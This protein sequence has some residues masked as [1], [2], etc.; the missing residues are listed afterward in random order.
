MADNPIDLNKIFNFS[1]TTPLDQVIAKTQQLNSVLDTMLQTAMKSATGMTQSMQQIQKSVESLE[2]EMTQAD[3]TTKKGQETITQGATTTAKAVAQNEEYKKSLAD[4]NETIKTLQGQIDKLSESNKKTGTDTDKQSNSL[5]SL[6]QQLK[7]ATDAY[8]KLGAATDSA[9]KKDAL[10]KVVNLNKAVQDGTK[11]INDAKKA[12]DIANGSYNELAQKVANATK[13]LKAMEGGVGSNSQQFKDLQKQ[14]AE[15][16]EK[17][18]TFDASIG[19][20]QRNVGDYAKATEGLKGQFEGLLGQLGPAGEKIE[21]IGGKA[22]SAGN[23]IKGMATGLGGVVTAAGAFIAASLGNYFTRTAEGAQQLFEVTTKLEYQWIQFKNVL[24]EVGKLIVDDLSGERILGKQ[25]DG[26]KSDFEKNAKE[27]RILQRERIKLTQEESDQELEKNKLVFDSRDKLH[28]SAEERL[29]D[30]KKALVILKELS[31]AATNQAEA[32]AKTKIADIIVKSG[33]PIYP[34]VD[35]NDKNQIA[36]VERRLSI[37]DSKEVSELMIKVNEARNIA[38]AGARRI[39]AQISTLDEEI[40]K[41]EEEL[42]REDLEAIKGYNDAIIKADVN[43]NNELLANIKTSETEKLAALEKNAKDEIKITENARDLALAAA[44]QKAK[45]RIRTKMG[46]AI[47]EAKSPE[48]QQAIIKADEVLAKQLLKI[49]QDFETASG[50]IESDARIKTTAL[51]NEKIKERIDI[52]VKSYSAIKDAEVLAAQQ[53][54]DNNNKVLANLDSTLTSRAQAI[55]DNAHLQ[56]QIAQDVYDKQLALDTAEALNKIATDN[57]VTGHLLEL[58]DKIGKSRQELSNKLNAINQKEVVEAR[59]NIFTTLARDLE[60]FNNLNEESKNKRL[61]EN[62]EEFNSGNIGLIEYQHQR[63]IILKSSADIEAEDKLNNLEKQKKDLLAQGL[64]TE[65][66]RTQIEK[67]Q[68]A[69]RL[70]IADREADLKAQRL[71]QL[72]D[73]ELQLANQT[74]DT[75]TTLLDNE[76][77]AKVQA[78]ESQMSA[79]QENHDKQIILA[80]DNAEIKKQIDLQYAQQQKMIQ[81][82]EAKLKHDQAVIDRDLALAKIIIN[83]AVAITETIAAGGYFAIPLSIIVG[84]LGTLESAKVASTPIPGYATGTEYSK[85]GLA[86]VAEQGP[87]LAI[88]RSGETVLYKEKQIAY[89]NEGTKI[90]NNARTEPILK[91][92]D[93][94]HMDLISHQ[95]VDIGIRDIK[96]GQSLNREVLNELYQIKDATKRNKPTQ[97]NYSKTAGVLWEYKMD[98]SNFVK[99]TKALS[100]GSWSQ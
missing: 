84:A 22:L 96:A 80:G 43:K 62:D 38:F 30:S 88:D 90:L 65:Q 35:I 45:D 27:M 57:N 54:I 55:H 52:E 39:Q 26:E 61:K 20:H 37:S 94:K 29:E 8:N 91:K 68:S 21:E 6:K 66:A 72:H 70:Q 24:T 18:K 58:N 19:N 83:T 86:Y 7:D 12:V 49:K 50:K 60:Y 16:N 51:I 28:R 32:E 53:A 4:L 3:I 78:L 95:L 99:K 79:L 2:A 93:S 40:Y 87:E 14:I 44:T 46:S 36:E 10:D 59:Q 64:L 33:R 25:E 23:L 98:E 73:K 56:K 97:V 63:R 5:A 77:N 81:K 76:T 82:Q 75:L 100:F 67:E 17:L 85:E 9:L 69:I 34:N 47:F 92:M 48:E 1:D 11:V 71:K 41:R 13:Q 15:G 31:E 89:L 42:R 74:L